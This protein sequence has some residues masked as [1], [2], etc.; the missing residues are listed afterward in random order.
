MAEDPQK[1]M[2]MPEDE[3]IHYALS[4]QANSYAHIIGS[5]ALQLRSLRQQTALMTSMLTA[6]QALVEH[7]KDLSTRTNRL[8]LAT[9]GVVV[10]TFIT[11]V[12]LIILTLNKQP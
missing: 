7:T 2:T 6:N 5:T 4:G 10:I 3:L 9:W 11:Q 8:V 1:L 12:A